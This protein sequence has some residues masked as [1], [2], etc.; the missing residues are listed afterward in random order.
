MLY[1]FMFLEIRSF[2]GIGENLIVKGFVF[3]S[4]GVGYSK[5]GKD[6][7]KERLYYSILYVSF[8]IGY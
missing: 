2:F 8:W 6:G 1:I 7:S 4:I 3:V 5:D